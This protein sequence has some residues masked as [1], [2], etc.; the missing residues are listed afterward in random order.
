MTL[1]QSVTE[2]AEVLRTELEAHNYRYYVLD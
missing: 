2:R 1:S